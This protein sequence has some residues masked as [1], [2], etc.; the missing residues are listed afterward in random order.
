MRFAPNLGH[1]WDWAA[2]FSKRRCLVCGVR[3]Y[4]W[5]RTRLMVVCPGTRKTKEVFMNDKLWDSEKELREWLFINVLGRDE[6]RCLDDDT[7]RHAVAENVARQVWERV[8]KI[9]EAIYLEPCH[10]TGEHNP[11]HTPQYICYYQRGEVLA[12]I[13]A[14]LGLEE[15]K[16]PRRLHEDCC[17]CG[18]RATEDSGNTEHR[19]LEKWTEG[20][21]YPR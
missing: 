6:S 11:V 12:R 14:V 1:E 3:Y 20:D 16:V 21:A 4:E 8:G 15:Q 5:A 9:L 19:A 10:V 7:D 18:P 2:I 17:F 13:L